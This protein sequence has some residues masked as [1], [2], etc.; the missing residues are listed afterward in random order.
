MVAVVVPRSS[1]LCCVLVLLSLWWSLSLHRGPCHWVVIEKDR[2]K[3]KE[4]EQIARRSLKHRLKS[5]L[6]SKN[7]FPQWPREERPT[8]D[9]RVGQC[10]HAC[11]YMER[12]ETHVC[13]VPGH[14]ET[15]FEC[16]H[17]GVPDGRTGVPSVPHHTRHTTTKTTTTTRTTHNDTQRHTTHNNTNQPTNTTTSEFYGWAAKT[18]DVGTSI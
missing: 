15:F 9:R 12:V 7:E 14:T 6:A 4:K 5:V 17:G 16:T 3:K 1:C 2:K 10:M 11:W 8:I 18:V 13:V